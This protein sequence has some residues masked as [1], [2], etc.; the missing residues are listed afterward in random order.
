MHSRLQEKT[1]FGGNFR[2]NSQADRGNAVQ[3]LGLASVPPIE[4]SLDGQV[5]SSGIPI[6]LLDPTT[7]PPEGL[8]LEHFSSGNQALKAPFAGATN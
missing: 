7:S 4:K 5:P 8:G 3:L 1:D 6:E 2:G